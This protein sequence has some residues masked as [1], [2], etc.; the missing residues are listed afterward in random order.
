MVQ[1]KL[2]EGGEGRIFRKATCRRI[3]A[4]KKRIK[5]FFTTTSACIYLKYKVITRILHKL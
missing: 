3:Y 1:E 5:T 4:I 2:K